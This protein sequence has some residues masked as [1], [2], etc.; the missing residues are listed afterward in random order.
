MVS[1][2]CIFTKEALTYVIGQLNLLLRQDMVAEARLRVSRCYLPES[3][4]GRHSQPAPCRD[5]L[6]GSAHFLPLH[7]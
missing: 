3:G 5:R 2:A 7:L 4:D 6:Q 1:A